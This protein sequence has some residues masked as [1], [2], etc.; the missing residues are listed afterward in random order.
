LNLRDTGLKSLYLLVF[1]N[2][3]QKGMLELVKKVKSAGAK[4]I[5]MTPPPFDAMSAKNCRLLPEGA[6]KYSYRE[7]FRDY[8]DVMKLYGEW[9]LSDLKGVADKVIDLYTPM[10]R[11]IDTCRQEDPDY[12]SGDGIHPGLGGHWII[13]KI[14]LRELFNARVERVP[15]YLVHSEDSH[16]FALAMEHS[17]IL[18]YAWKEFVG[19]TNPNRE[20]ALPM[21]EAIVAAGRIEE[22]ILQAVKAQKEELYYSSAF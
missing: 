4:A 15:E 20:Q 10:R 14:L 19:H 11:F 1:V 6:V 9:V 18:H 8:D 13:A 22:N 3:Y 16:L 2:L 12:I 17:R 21:E 5:V 7:P